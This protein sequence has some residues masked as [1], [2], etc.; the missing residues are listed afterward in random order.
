MAR[1][2]SEKIS[3]KLLNVIRREWGISAGGDET[4]AQAQL[5][6]LEPLAKWLREGA[7]S[8]KVVIRAVQ[9]LLADAA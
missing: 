9:L 5:R 1:T 4:T 7:D 2:D 6:A 3:A 8:P